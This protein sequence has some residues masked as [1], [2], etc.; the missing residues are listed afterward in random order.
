ME[1]KELS[2]DE[3]RAIVADMRE[4]VRTKRDQARACHA[5]NKHDVGHRITAE[6]IVV[7]HWA[8]RLASMLPPRTT[9]QP[10]AVQ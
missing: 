2:I 4:Q 10:E 8:N 5:A 6:A 3:I 9:R 7:E 1:S